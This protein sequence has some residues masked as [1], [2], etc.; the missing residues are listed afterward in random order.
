MKKHPPARFKKWLDPLI[1]PHLLFYVLPYMMML[2]TA[3]TVAQKYVG[4]FTATHL[5]FS[6]FILWAGPIPLPGGA[7]ALAVLF[8][9]LAGYFVVKSQ[10]TPT[11]IG[12]S[13]THLGV[14]VLLLGGLITLVNKQE[15]F[16]ILRHG[17]QADAFYDYHTRYFTVEKNG[18]VVAR[19]TFDALKQGDLL[20]ADGLSLLIEKT[21]TNSLIDK[22]GK[23]QPIEARKEEETNQAGLTFSLTADG[24]IRRFMTTEFL[25]QQPRLKT[26]EGVYGFTLKRSA[27]QLPFRL[28]LNEL[29][30]DVYPGT[31]TAKSYET[32]FTVLEENHEWP[33]HVLM[34]EPLRYKGYTFYQASVLTLPNGEQ[35]SVL[36]TVQDVGWLFPYAATGLI[37]VGLLINAWM[38]RHAKK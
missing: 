10:W 7:A 14:I 15:G 2:L 16:I 28:R 11:T 33:A 5:F 36:N 4:L 32:R 27:H 38:R 13:L 3:G 37:S 21:Y 22:D 29:N 34:N 9:N 8:V 17:Q 20:K 31:D 35:A 30:Q 19:V 25:A 6:S 1:S 18:A 26:A 23:L 12:S 24:K